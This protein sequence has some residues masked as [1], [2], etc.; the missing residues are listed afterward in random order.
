MNEYALDRFN[1]LQKQ[2]FM[3][4]R[5]QRMTTVYEVWTVDG[6]TCVTT[7]KVTA[8]MNARRHQGTIKTKRELRCQ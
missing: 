7:N 8:E 4:P 6:V 2:G 3:K 1:D 5:K